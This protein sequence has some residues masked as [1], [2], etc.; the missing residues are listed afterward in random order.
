MEGQ[1]RTGGKILFYEGST[2]PEETL[3]P[4]SAGKN[5]PSA[6]DSK[7]PAGSFPSTGELIGS[8]GFLVGFLFLLI[9]LLKRRRERES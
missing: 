5:P 9:V 2:P 7:K 1:V 3:Q 6:P 8:M 4:E